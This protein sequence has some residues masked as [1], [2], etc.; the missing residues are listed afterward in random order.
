M[1]SQKRDASSKRE[2]QD[3]RPSSSVLLLSPTNEILL[4]HRVKTSS[5]FASAHVFP[6]GNLD[7]FHDGDIPAPGSPERHQD[8]PAY[9]MG[10]IR[11]TFEETGILLATK[12]G[13]LVNLS[14]EQ[15]DLARKDIHD[16]KVRFDDFLKSLGA[17]ADTGS[18][19]APM[20]LAPT[21]C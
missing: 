14:A 7:S 11:E 10:A 13:A 12:D 16:N 3:P 15:R 6:G 5:S 9:R 8:G 4:L 19:F 2:V 17:V 1:A 21:E 20:P 18:S